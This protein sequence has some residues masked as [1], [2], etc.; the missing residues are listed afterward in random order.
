VIY[1]FCG[2]GLI[3]A[4]GGIM[5]LSRI[6]YGIVSL[7]VAL[8]ILLSRYPRWGYAAISFFTIL[9]SM[10]SIRFSQSYFNP[11]IQI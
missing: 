3:L 4:S 11:K 1:G 9:M 7:S 2:M 10:L 8:G 6:S 5:S